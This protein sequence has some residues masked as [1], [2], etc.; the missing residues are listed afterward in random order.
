MKNSKFATH[1]RKVIVAHQGMR[2]TACKVHGISRT[3]DYTLRKRDYLGE[4]LEHRSSRPYRIK[5]KFRPE[6]L[7]T[8]FVKS[9]YEK[10]RKPGYQRFYLQLKHDHPDIDCSER[11]IRKIYKEDN[12]KHKKELKPAVRYEKEKPGDMAHQDLKYLPKVSGCKKRFYFHELLDDCTRMSTVSI[13]PN[14][15]AV[16]TRDGLSANSKKLNIKFSRIL[17]DNGAEFSYRNLP[18]NRIPKDKI[19][20]LGEFCEQNNMRQKFT[21]VCRPQTNGKSERLHKTLEDEVLEAKRFKSHK[22]MCNSIERWLR[23]YNEERVHMGI[24][25]TPL[26]KMKKHNPNY[27]KPKTYLTIIK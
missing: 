17:Q 6:K 25:M 14:K 7:T 27:K 15:T 11:D 20:P 22:D 19:H 3:W 8:E 13:L 12:L 21:R 1:T 16:T 10:H 24:R 4:S 2:K 26:E 23:Y 5:I 9:F 18:S